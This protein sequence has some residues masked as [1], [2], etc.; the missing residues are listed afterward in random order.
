MWL[1]FISCEF[2][3]CVLEE[4]MNVVNKIVGE[5]FVE[6]GEI[7]EGCWEVFEYLV[8]EYFY[9]YLNSFEVSLM[10]LNVIDEFCDE[11]MVIM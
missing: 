11:L 3:V 5:L 1:E 10:V 6:V 2:L 4:W 9:G 8:S 7:L